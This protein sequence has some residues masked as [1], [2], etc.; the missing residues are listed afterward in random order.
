MGDCLVFE[1]CVVGGGG[2]G[3]FDNSFCF[4]TTFEFFEPL[5]FIELL[6]TDGTGGV[7]LLPF[8]VEFCGVFCNNDVFFWDKLSALVFLD[9]FCP[10]IEFIGLAC[11]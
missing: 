8:F 3:V 2:G 10:E 1:F 4:G 5:V 6:E 9:L 11:I 7:L